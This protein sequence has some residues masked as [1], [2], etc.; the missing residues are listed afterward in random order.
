MEVTVKILN[1][2]N[3]CEF[4]LSR[5]VS[6][7]DRIYE[8][9]T[10]ALLSPLAAKI[11]GFPWAAKVQITPQSVIV[12]KQDWVQWDILAEPLKGLISEHFASFS[13]TD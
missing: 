13:Q 10:E 3:G 9:S 8:N 11:F 12:T 4:Q 7:F 6:R 2:D 1:D 5:E